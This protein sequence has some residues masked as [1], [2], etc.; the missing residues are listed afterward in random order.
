[1]PRWNSLRATAYLAAVLALLVA[2]TF[3]L[4]LHRGPALVLWS[5][6]F[7]LANAIGSLLRRSR[8]RRVARCYADGEDNATLATLAEG[9]CVLEGTV[10]YAREADRAMHIEFTQIG[11]ESESSGSWSHKWTETHRK[12]TVQP[13]YLRRSDGSRVRVEPD[14]A[15]SRLYDE[16]EHK[17]LVRTESPPTR[18]R[19]A[20]LMPH[21]HVW[22]SGR[23]ER[24]ID[25]EREASQQVGYREN[26]AGSWVVRGAPTLLVSSISLVAHFRARAAR[27]TKSAIVS[28]CLLIA[29]LAMGERYMDRA[30]GVTLTGQVEH[31]TALTDDDDRVTGYRATA[32]HAK[33]LSKSE[34]LDA[35]PKIGSVM[36]FRVG[37]HTDNQG[38]TARFSADESLLNFAIALLLLIIDGVL[39]LSITGSL[40]WYRSDRVKV[41]DHGSGRLSAG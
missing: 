26:A 3:A 37:A 2:G 9:P 4:G 17:V 14:P 5:M 41:E 21:E 12:L 7:L 30:N 36:P 1:M 29:P 38:T 28:L 31:V 32:R 25:P 15:Q 6:V 39:T 34:S 40:P 23:L 19:F 22:V 33:G 11:S 35:A 13:F 27:H 16:L 24:G 18:I 8:A 20:T 10:E